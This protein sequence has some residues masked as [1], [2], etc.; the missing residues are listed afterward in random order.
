MVSAG[1]A[2]YQYNYIR[3]QQTLRKK[4]KQLHNMAYAASPIGG[5][6]K[7]R[8]L[9]SEYTSVYIQSSSMAIICFDLCSSNELAKEENP[10]DID[11]SWYLLP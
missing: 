3:K 6:V 11:S 8:S 2:N 5:E 9:L 4:D 7:C 1:S 10:L